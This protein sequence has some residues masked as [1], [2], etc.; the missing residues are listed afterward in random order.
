MAVV[1]RSLARGLARRRWPLIF[2]S[3]HPLSQEERNAIREELGQLDAAR[4]AMREQ[5]RALRDRLRFSRAE[6]IDAEIAKLEHRI[7]H[8]SMPL[9]EEKKL[10]VEIKELTRSRNEVDGLRLLSAKI[11]EQEAVRKMISDSIRRKD[12]EISEIKAEQVQQKQLYDQL[13]GKD[14]QE[15]GDLPAMNAQKDQ[16]YQEIKQTREAITQLKASFRAKE[17]AW[18]ANEKVVREQQREEKKKRWVL[19]RTLP[20][21]VSERRCALS[22]SPSGS[23]RRALI[24]P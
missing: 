1:P 3:L 13:R 11:G 21:V 20:E 15:L 6:D 17:D 19:H 16:L 5:L 9:N 23:N 8:T 7:A 14:E 12:A 24:E 22:W 2:F 4:D 10:I 18:W